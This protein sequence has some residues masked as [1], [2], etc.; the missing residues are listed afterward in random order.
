M[1]IYEHFSCHTRLPVKLTDVRDHILETGVVS[2]I[3]RK[4]IPTISLNV[5]GGLH[6]YRE[7]DA[8]GVF[9]KV[10]RIGYPAG[11]SEGIRR[12][13]QV[14]EMLHCLD[15]HEATSPT[16]AKV[17]ALISDLIQEGAERTM[18]LAAD[19]DHNGIMHAI[20]ILLPRDA[21]DEIRPAFKRGDRTLE[22]IAAEAKLPTS[23]CDV[24]L[25]DRWRTVLEKI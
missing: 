15:E 21:L 1:N 11:A 2:R 20:C 10:A 23:V 13:I 25:T 18:G 12:L 7:K 3:I 14:K 8:E 5:A 22:Q 6:L 24:A 17:D 19:A 9:H 4:A 16:K